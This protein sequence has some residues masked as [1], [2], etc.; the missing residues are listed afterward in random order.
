MNFHLGSVD[1]ILLDSFGSIRDV[2]ELMCMYLHCSVLDAC[3]ISILFVLPGI[4][5]E[6]NLGHVR[7]QIWICGS[8]AGL[9]KLDKESG[10][11]LKSEGSEKRQKYFLRS[12]AEKMKQI[13][14]EVNFPEEEEKDRKRKMLIVSRDIFVFQNRIITYITDLAFLVDV[15]IQSALHSDRKTFLL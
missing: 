9:Q 13:K 11:C 14:P 8:K 2:A 12:R 5:I 1:G 7:F 3:K 6:I 15:L 10:L 4:C